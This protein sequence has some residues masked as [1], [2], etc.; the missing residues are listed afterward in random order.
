MHQITLGVL[1]PFDLTVRRQ[2]T[3]GRWILGFFERLSLLLGSHVALD[4]RPVHE[5]AESRIHEQS[6][7]V[8]DKL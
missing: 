4:G 3:V 2:H 7:R 8:A 1:E 6:L 5:D